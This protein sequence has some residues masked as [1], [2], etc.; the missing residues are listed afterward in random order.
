MRLN[1]ML[2]QAG[3]ASRR[4]ADELIV[5]GKVKV[6]GKVCKAVHTLVDPQKDSVIYQKKTLHLEQKVYYLLNKPKGYVCTSAKERSRRAIDLIDTDQRLFTVGRLD[7][8]TSGLIIVTNDGG[9]ANQIMHP[10]SEVPKEYLVKIDKE[11][12]HDHLVKIAEGTIVEGKKVVPC[13]VKK[14]RRNTLK[15][16]VYDGKKHEVRLLC[17]DANLDVLELKRIRI[18]PLVLGKIP[19]GAYRH[20][21]KKELA[22]FCN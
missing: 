21:T 20:L 9:F 14:V 1:K 19:E 4:K 2:A 18:G 3:I 16:V 11:V 8:D 12:L 17:Q 13:S 22:L 5:Q 10:S 6:N 15:V 7:K